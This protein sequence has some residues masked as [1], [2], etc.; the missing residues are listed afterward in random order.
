MLFS[1][2]GQ[3]SNVTMF[4]FDRYDIKNPAHVL[5]WIRVVTK[6]MASYLLIPEYDL[7]RTD[8]YFSPCFVG[9]L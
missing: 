4:D 6:D 8:L 9:E 2:Q 3:L 1:E 5:E 7:I